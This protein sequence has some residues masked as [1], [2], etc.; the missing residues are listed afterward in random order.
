MDKRD[1]EDAIMQS[2]EEMRGVMEEV[3]KEY[4]EPELRRAFGEMWRQIPPEYKAQM[5]AKIVKEMDKLY[6]G[7]TPQ[8][9]TPWGV[10]AQ[11]GQGDPWT[12]KGR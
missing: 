10:I 7:E 1:F 5:D 2:R 3:N 4:N 8:E 6:G 11:Q 12:M 9:P